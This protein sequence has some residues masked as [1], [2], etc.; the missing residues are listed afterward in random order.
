MNE[1]KL[2]RV[3]RHFKGDYYLVEDVARHSETGEEM[4][5]YRRLYGDGS[6]WVRP[7]AMFLSEVDHEKYP[8]VTQK[9]RFELQDIESRVADR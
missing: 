8:E 3:Y 9:Y 4:V 2:H 1:L 7:K 5:V 6:L